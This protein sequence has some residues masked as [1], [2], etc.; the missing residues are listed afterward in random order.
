MIHPK[1]LMV[2]LPVQPIHQTA[3]FGA[4]FGKGAFRIVPVADEYHSFVHG[5]DGSS[6]DG[7]LHVEVCAFYA[8]SQMLQE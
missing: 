1:Y 5:D 6:D 8:Q 7:V 4:Q 2:W 3:I